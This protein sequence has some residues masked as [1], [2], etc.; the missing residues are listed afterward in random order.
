MKKIFGLLAIIGASAALGYLKCMT[1]LAK[2][3]PGETITV[4]FGKNSY[5]STTKNIR[6]KETKTN[7]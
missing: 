6:S 7:E 2:Q 3:H 5:I 1:D 4:K